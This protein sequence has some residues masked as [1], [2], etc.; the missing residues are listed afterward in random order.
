MIQFDHSFLAVEER[1]GSQARAVKEAQMALIP[2]PKHITDF[3]PIKV[4]YINETITVLQI[5]IFKIL[6][7]V[8]T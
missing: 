8:V 3:P 6:F 7:F 4:L 5:E 2:S 1:R